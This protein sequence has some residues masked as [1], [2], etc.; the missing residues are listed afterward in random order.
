MLCDKGAEF[1]EA[2]GRVIRFDGQTALIEIRRKGACGDSCA[3]CSG[4]SAQLMQI[5]AECPLNAS[6]GDWVKISSDRSFVFLGL[7]II[8]LL[9]LA[10]PLI[11]YFLLA[12]TGVEIFFVFLALIFSLLLI[13]FL[14]KNQRFQARLKPK[15]I[16][17]IVKARIKDE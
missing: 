5:E 11:A 16:E 7:F 3:H 9:P 13:I 14:N 6:K 10:L 2:E 8:F 4:C 17:V 12:G 1:L 15:V